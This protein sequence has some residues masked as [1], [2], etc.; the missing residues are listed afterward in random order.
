MYNTPIGVR[1]LEGAERR[2][3]IAALDCLIDLWVDGEAHTGVRVFDELQRNQQLAALYLVGRS[4]LDPAASPL[5]QTA[6]LEATLAAIYKFLHQT[7]H[8]EVETEDDDA[9]QSWREMVSE[10]GQQ[11]Q[12][13]VPSIDCTDASQWDWVV[14]CLADKVFW[15]ADWEMQEAYLDA[16][17]RTGAVG[18][19]QLGIATDYFTSVVPDPRDDEAPR[20][21]DKLRRMTVEVRETPKRRP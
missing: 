1:V 6:E 21:L 13:V 19:E 17:P 8:A 7:V 5:H 14:E 4:I 10:A 3:F 9:E 20:L 12:L 15:D 16:Q 11:F 18:K 2:L